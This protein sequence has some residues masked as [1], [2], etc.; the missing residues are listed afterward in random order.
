[1]GNLN[2][3][4]MRRWTEQQA[5]EEVKKAI[6]RGAPGGGFILADNHGEIPF[7]VPDEVLLAISEAVHTWGAYPLKWTN[8]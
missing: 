6:A 4:E 1:L 2:G 5:E 8:R 3:I 7:Q